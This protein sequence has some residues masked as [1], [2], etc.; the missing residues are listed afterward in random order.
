MSRD[1]A[2]CGAQAGA[3]SVAR[4]QQ[5]AT[6]LALLKKRG[7]WSPPRAG[8]PTPPGPGAFEDAMTEYRAV[9]DKPPA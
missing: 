7:A 4:T 1:T 2:R 9:R 5:I 3:C 6:A 8:G